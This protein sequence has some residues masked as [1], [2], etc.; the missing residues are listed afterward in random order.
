MSGICG[1]WM[2]DEATISLA[3]I[4]AKLE[5]RGPDGTREWSDG[6][7]AL[8]H[9]LLA[10]TPEALVEQLPLGDAASGCTITADA[11]LDN[12]D[13]LIGALGLSGETRTIGDGELILRAYLKWGE[14]CPEHLLGDFAFA[15]WDAQRQ[16]LFCARDQMGM[17]QLIY[18]H[19][20][21]FLFAFATEAAALVAHPRVQQRLNE[22]RIADFLDD[23]EGIDFSS[24]FFENVF[25]LPP[26]HVLMVD[27]KG[28]SLRRYWELIPGPELKLDSDQAYADAFFEVFTEAVRCRLRSAGPVGSMLSGGL[29][30][31]SIVAVASRLLITECRGPLLTFSAVGPD[32][33]NCAE[34]RAIHS[35]L[36][37]RGLSSTL[38]DYTKLEDHKDE[39]IQLTAR[40]SEPFDGHMTLVRTVYLAAHRRGVK[41]M[42]DGAS[43]DVVLTS[44]NRVAQLF[45]TARIGKALSEASAEKRFWGSEWNAPRAMV[46]AAWAAFAPERLRTARR[47]LGWSYQDWRIR[48]GR[49][50]IA[51]DFAQKFSL[52]D[53]R[54]RFRRHIGT[55]VPIGPEHRTQSILHPHLIVG[56][57]RYDRVA[58]ALAV[59]PRDP[60]LDIR[61]IAFCLSLPTSQLQ[62]GGWPKIILRRAIAGIVP[63]DVIWRRGKEHLGWTFTH[64]LLRHCKINLPDKA[65]LSKY[66]SRSTLSKPSSRAP[67]E[68]DR[69]QQ[70][71]LLILSCWLA[72]CEHTDES[73]KRD[74]E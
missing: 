29:D 65:R 63:A 45:R 60:F 8:G 17:R 38:V 1:V 64:A 74:G 33:E 73:L 48:T 36:R 16:R 26:A 39:L 31:N 49:G 47:N 34:T 19:A 68:M 10:T 35:A 43:G 7:V 52:I 27:A 2:F 70:F 21:G 6:G 71:E 28:I 67:S 4:L 50:R 55:G 22:A 59:E 30:S 32:R 12:R 66:V 61:L 69:D 24:T 40:C 72:R 5:Q 56:R 25:R 37:R 3:P 62:D 41:V 18:T 54:G 44:G 58:S 23:L 15:I 13:A 46:A 42:L 20:P 57:E 11:R 53:R 14:D 9:A 51:A